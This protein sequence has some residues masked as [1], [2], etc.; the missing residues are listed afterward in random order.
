MVPYVFYPAAAPTPQLVH[1]VGRPRGAV[2]LPQS[3]ENLTAEE[4]LVSI[5][6]SG[7]LR[8]FPVPD[9]VLNHCSDEQWVITLEV[10]G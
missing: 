2:A 1:F 6:D 10:P 8:A 7:H 4:R 5:L 9:A 3:L